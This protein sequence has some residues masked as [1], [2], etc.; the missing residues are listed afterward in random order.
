MLNTLINSTQKGILEIEDAIENKDWETINQTAHRIASPLKYIYATELYD[1]IKKIE[2][3][4]EPK[5][6]KNNEM[7]NHQFN[8]F[9]AEFN[10]LTTS[11]QDYMKNA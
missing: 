5:V 4:T 1:L 3:Y 9:K 11:I 7:I 2:V 8:R 6:G 10:T